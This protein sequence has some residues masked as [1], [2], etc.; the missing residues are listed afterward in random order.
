MDNAHFLMELASESRGVPDI[1]D[2]NLTVIHEKLW[3]FLSKLTLSYTGEGSSSVRVET[4]K[5]L[6]ESACF[7][8]GLGLEAEGKERSLAKNLAGENYEKLFQKGFNVVNAR[9]EAGKALL[10]KAEEMAL[11]VNNTAYT[12][13]VGELRKFFARYNTYYFAH[14]IPC[15]IDYPLAL[16]VDEKFLGIEYIQ[17]YLSRF[18]L[19]TAFC[20]LFNAGA[21]RRLVKRVCPDDG[22]ISIYESVVSHAV[23]L[24]L[25][26][27]DILSL[28]MTAGVCRS[29]Q[30]IL[31]E[32]EAPERW[33]AAVDTLTQLLALDDDTEAYLKKTAETSF[34][35]LRHAA[36]LGRLEALLP[37][38][39]GT[40]AVRTVQRRYIDNKPMDNDK[41]R[42]LMDQITDCRAPAAK[43]A[44]ALENVGSL[45]DLFEIL[46]ICL[47]GEES[48]ALFEA[49]DETGL[50]LLSQRLKIVQKKHPDWHSESGWEEKFEA[51]MKRLTPDLE[52]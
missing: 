1:G 16:P 27:G 44:L 21:V 4:A 9:V 40:L 33:H 23:A 32:Q 20:R 29:V 52:D 42:A 12:G 11:D 34:A 35:H 2:K 50:K 19:E 15:M 39:Q 38:E 5:S 45:R 37:A 18:V 8:I 47:W 25:I 3:S 17:E 36:K 26:K 48:T 14:E 30:S 6:L 41:L 43:V 49:L 22:L 10:Q 46:N 7:L 24:T 31:C 28:D 13:T 51:H